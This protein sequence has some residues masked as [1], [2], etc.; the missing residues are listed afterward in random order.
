[1]NHAP[2]DKPAQD[3]P[4]EIDVRYIRDR[5]IV[6]IYFNQKINNVVQQPAQAVAL[7]KALL[8]G[9]KALDPKSVEGITWPTS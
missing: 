4:V 7:A 8:E 3:R 2:G 1:M 5:N 9:A 6:G